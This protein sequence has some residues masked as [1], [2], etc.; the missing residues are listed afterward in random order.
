MKKIFA[1]SILFLIAS[2]GALKN[3]PKDPYVGIFD[4][5]IFEVDNFGDIPIKWTLLKEGENYTS[6]ME[7]SGDGTSPGEIE[8][9]S[10]I[11]EDEVFTIE[12]YT[13]GYDIYFE[14]S[15]EEATISGSMMGMF[16]IDGARIK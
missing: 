1:I 13:S 15:V 2:C 16:N 12:A 6:Q 11:L 10:T 3:S 8:V 5:I 4:F 7:F 14:L 9:N